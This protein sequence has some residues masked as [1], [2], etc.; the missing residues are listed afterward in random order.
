MP[1]AVYNIAT[2]G[3]ATAV[4]YISDTQMR[5]E[6][7]VPEGRTK[8]RAIELFAGVGGFRLG[9]GEQ[10]DIVWSNQ[11]EPSTK[12][13]HASDVY[14][15]RFGDAGHVCQDIAE[16]LQRVREEETTIP[17]HDLLVGGFPCQ[18]YSVARV[19]SQ[20][21]GLV[22]KKGVLWWSI[23]EVL[24][25]Y[26]PRFVLLEN[27]DRLLN[28][29]ANQRGRD[30]A[31]ILASLSQLGY[32]VEWRIVNAADYGFPQRRRRVFI[33]GERTDVGFNDPTRTLLNDGLLARALP[34]TSRS[35]ASSNDSVRSFTLDER[36]NVVSDTFGVG[37]KMSPFQRAGIMHES[38]VHTLDIDA[39]FEG[40]R[41]TLG[42]ILQ[43]HEEIDVTFFIPSSQ[44]SDWSYLKGA[45]NEK[46]THR[47]SGTPYVYSEGAIAFPDSLDKPSRT[48]LTGEGGPS[49]SRFKHIVETTDGRFRRLTPIEMERLNGFPDDWTEG[50]TDGRRAFL[51]GNALVVGVVARISS[52]LE[53]E[54]NAA[55]PSTVRY[56]I[57]EPVSAVYSV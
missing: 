47:N 9:L 22:G 52:V 32:R 41:I 29:P 27:V 10:W 4:K 35:E 1:G 51:M 49:P 6:V 45:K 19:L 50:I 31:I 20:A 7:P 12:R 36:L 23:H 40:E 16:I 13:Q 53:E 2:M 39:R 43:P 38:Q 54:F 42:D 15:K 5:F 21:A 30:F 24:S 33:V 3:S 34:V 26:Q 57:S 28:S 17:S 48:I 55:K 56:R 44:L 25:R 8:P 37:L 11:W 18:D 46:R 14:V